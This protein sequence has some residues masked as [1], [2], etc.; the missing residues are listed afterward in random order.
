MMKFFLGL[1]FFALFLT[2][3]CSKD[4]SNNDDASNIANQEIQCPSIQNFT[5]SQNNSQLNLDISSNN[6]ALYFEYSIQSTGSNN[7]ENGIIRPLTELSN[8]INIQEINL[9][10][11]ETYILFVRAVCQDGSKSSWSNAKTISIVEYCD[12]PKNLLL[13][14]NGSGTSLVWDYYN[15]VSYF[16]VEYGVQGFT[17]GTGTNIQ[18]NSASF[19][20]IPLQ[21]DTTYDFYVRAY[22][23]N[24]L[25]W[26]NW[27]EP[28]SYYSQNMQNLCT[29]P[30]NV[31]F[32]N[33][34]SG[35]IRAEWS[36]NG[37]SL[38]EV[39]VVNPGVNVSQGSITTISSGSWPVF[40]HGSGRDFYV[41][42]V[43]TGG[44]RT[45]WSGPWAT[46]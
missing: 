29:T 8:I 11:P 14:N 5:I 43:C 31:A 20:D 28:K 30:S 40:N 15:T 2:V 36:L 24:T 46:Y 1:S 39:V 12:T 23:N 38:F 10:S 4:D 26:S 19:N 42:A 18:V 33:E 32:Y 45:P 41:R 21:A 27:S 6:P 9:N 17:L 16:Q 44:N 25:G 35:F 3:G 37:E 7:P 22:C 34:G 13:S